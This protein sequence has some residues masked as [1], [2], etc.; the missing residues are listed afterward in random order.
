MIDSLTKTT[1]RQTGI[2]TRMQLMEITADFRFCTVVAMT[3]RSAAVQKMIGTISQTLCNH[4][5]TTTQGTYNQL[6]RPL[7]LRLSPPQHNDR[8]PSKEVEEPRRDTKVA[9]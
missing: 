2:P 3:S 4:E 1:T 8:G 6:E 5:T 7:Q 9:D